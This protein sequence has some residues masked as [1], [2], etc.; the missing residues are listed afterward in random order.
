M[1]VAESFRDDVCVQVTDSIAPGYSSIITSPMDL[2]TVR[3]K[4]TKGRYSCL[5]DMDKDIKLIRSNCLKFN[6]LDPYMSEVRCCVHDGG[7]E[8]CACLLACLLACVL[9]CLLA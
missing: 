5:E 7:T 8:T 6:K 2:S 9:A 1:R 3:K 4:I